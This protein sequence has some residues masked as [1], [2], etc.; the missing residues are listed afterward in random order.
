MVEMAPAAEP[1]QFRM[2]FAG[3][4]FNTLWYLRQLCPQ[5]QTPYLTR[6][7]NDGISRDM[8]R[9]M[10]D[11]GIDTSLIGQDAARS[12]GLYLITLLAGERSFSY[13]RDRSAARQVAADPAAV[14]SALAHADLIY[15]SGISMAILEDEGR[16][17]LLAALGA[18]RDAGAVIVFDSN[19]RPRLW[20][21][22]QAM[23]AGVT[24]AAAVSDM[25]LPS[26]DDEALFFKDTSPQ[27][28]VARYLDLGC[29][30]VVVK[31]GPGDVHY[32]H[33]GA[34]GVVAVAQATAIVDTTAAGDSF[35]AGCLASLVEDGDIVAAIAK[36]A[37]VAA[38]VI[39]QR[40]ALVRL[41]TS[42]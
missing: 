32:V 27:E 34:S 1:G 21:S 13:W 10:Q 28:T 8:L 4:T 3:D 30:S 23:C 37:E 25:V 31:N 26:Y 16:A 15:F 40:G 35:N 38:E 5:W 24:D 11:A 41:Q 33:D 19:L 39:G 36:G 7:G 42:V 22:E 9:M 18:A 29:R 17:N 14:S 2:G 20:S 12:V 6:V